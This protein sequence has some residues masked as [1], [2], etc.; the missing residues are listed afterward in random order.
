MIDNI[1]KNETVYNRT[2]VQL[3]GKPAY[4]GGRPGLSLFSSLHTSY[5]VTMRYNDYTTIQFNM[6]RGTNRYNFWRNATR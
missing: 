5:I 6:L 3:L 4:I 1:S 2:D